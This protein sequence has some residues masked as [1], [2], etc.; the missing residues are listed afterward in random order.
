MNRE[1]HSGHVVVVTAGGQNP[2]VM[3]NALKAQF[4]NLTVLLED[5]ESRAVFLKRRMRRLGII[6][7]AGQFA[8]MTFSKFGKRF[9]ARRAGEIIR[10]HGLSAATDPTI[11]VVKIHSINDLPAVQ[12]I[13]ALAPDV[14]FLISCRMLKVNTLAAMP[15]P[16]INFHAGINPQY[17]GL[18]GG[19]WA[20]VNDDAANFGATVHL[21]DPGVDTGDVLYQSRMTPSKSDTMLTYPLLQTAAS[22][23]IAVQAISDALNGTLSP[24]KTSGSSQQWYHPPLWTWLW[25]GVFRHIW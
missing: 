21:V 23:G 3:I 24:V 10:D 18:M 25:N 8:T 6:Q 2:Q 17:R 4:S 15:C 13:T 19:Y 5:P 20:L 9:A 14:V 1:R 22:T 16:V 11:P 12:T 7:T